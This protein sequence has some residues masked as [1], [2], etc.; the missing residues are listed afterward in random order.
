MF[1]YPRH[2]HSNDH[3]SLT[4]EAFTRNGV[5]ECGKKIGTSNISLSEKEEKP[6]GIFLKSQMLTKFIN[7]AL[8]IP[9]L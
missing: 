6:F 8:N 1:D 2:A 5:D 4:I 7:N 3:I 9:R